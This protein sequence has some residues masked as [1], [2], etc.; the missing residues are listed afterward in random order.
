MIHVPD[1]MFRWDDDILGNG[2]QSAAVPGAF[3]PV[4][5]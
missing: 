3:V 1:G 4:F 2:I 5:G